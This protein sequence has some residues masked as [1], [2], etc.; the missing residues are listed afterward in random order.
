MKLVCA[1]SGLRGK[2]KTQGRNA[3]L[4]AANTVSIKRTF[5]FPETDGFT[6]TT[7]TNISIG[8]LACRL[9]GAYKKARD[10]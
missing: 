8:F 3:V 7:E 6:D 2:G 10:G 1:Y 9:Y 5:P 4:A